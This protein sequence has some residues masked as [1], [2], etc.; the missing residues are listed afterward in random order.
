MKSVSVPD[1]RPNKIKEV[2]VKND[3]TIISIER[4][5]GEVVQRVESPTLQAYLGV[6]LYPVIGFLL[7]RS[8]L[9][10]LVW[11]FR[12]FFDSRS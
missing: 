7:P 9:H 11:V 8:V 6:L 5:N 2:T 1:L 12:G 10:V 4:D 3:H